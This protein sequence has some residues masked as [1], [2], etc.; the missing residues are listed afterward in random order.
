[1]EGPEFSERYGGHDASTQQVRIPAMPAVLPGAC[2]PGVPYPLLD[3]LNPTLGWQSGSS[4]KGS[5]A[6]VI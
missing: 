6:F 2:T 5:S 4:D 1:M 3:D